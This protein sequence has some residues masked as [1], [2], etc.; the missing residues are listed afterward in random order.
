MLHAA[1]LSAFDGRPALRV[2]PG[3]SPARVPQPAPQPWRALPVR[4]VHLA[5]PTPPTPPATMRASGKEARAADAPDAIEV[6]RTVDTTES[7]VSVVLATSRAPDASG[8]VPVS[9]APAT[10]P[11]ASGAFHIAPQP[12]WGR[13]PA[14][15]SDP[16]P[17]PLDDPSAVVAPLGA[18]V[19]PPARL[20]AADEAPG[21]AAGSATDRTARGPTPADQPAGLAAAGPGAAA[22]P[23]PPPAAGQ[24]WHLPP[25]AELAYQA[26]HGSRLGQAR[27]SWEPGAAGDA[28]EASLVLAY[29][30]QPAAALRQRSQGRIDATG[31][32]PQHY[33]DRR[34][35]SSPR[36]VHFQPEAGRI[37]YSASAASWPWT[38]GAQDRLSWLVQ[39][40]A[41]AAA[42]RQAPPPGTRVSLTVAGLRGE[43]EGWD[44]VVQ[45]WEDL[46]GAPGSALRLTRAPQHRH[47]HRLDVWLRPA[48]AAWP[49]L[50]RWSAPGRE[51][52]TLRLQTTERLDE[53]A[54]Q[55]SIAAQQR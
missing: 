48:A 23:P 35:R 1:L 5:P 10:A 30:G 15:A 34:D 36:A 19:A 25:A 4:V 33:L 53:P 26:R 16:A 17:A 2:E 41:V 40:T 7:P 8:A 51:D 22:G 14:R 37:S 38:P 45:G 12:P 31:L 47:D 29:A 54:L 55:A 20:Q 6:P 49:L 13:R 46:P 18:P 32:V 44:F 27:L 52:L 43:L 11:E 21:E 50:L 3:A 9:A 39:L 28:Y 24:P 42:W